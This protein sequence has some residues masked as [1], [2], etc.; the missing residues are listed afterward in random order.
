MTKRDAKGRLIG[1]N[2]SLNPG[3]RPPVSAEVREMMRAALPSAVKRLVGL[4][5]SEDERVALA[6]IEALLVR[7][8]GKPTG[9]PEDDGQA[10]RPLVGVEVS[11]LLEIM[12][13]G[14]NGPTE[15]Q[16]APEH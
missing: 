14:I 5:E 16:D 6:A 4:V 3:G 2:G 11:Q 9:A 10:N 8:L 13:A 1:G 12:R 15:K 7:V